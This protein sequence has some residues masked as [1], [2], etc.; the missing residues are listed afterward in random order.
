MD[1]ATLKPDELPHFR[2]A[3]QAAS[4]L[5]SADVVLITGT[6]LVNDTL[7]HLLTLCRSSARVVLV[8]PT[9][10]LLPDPFPASAGSTF[11]A[12]SGLP[13]RRLSGCAG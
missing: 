1:A 6:T 9:V 7:E 8:G 3:E 13:G 4:V 12:A 2:P 5:P 11:S 10:G